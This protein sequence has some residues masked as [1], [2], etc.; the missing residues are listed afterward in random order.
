MLSIFFFFFFFKVGI[1]LGM[2]LSF[3]HCS[4]THVYIFFLYFWI[5]F[6]RFILHLPSLARRL[7][8][9]FLRYG[10]LRH[11]SRWC[12][13]RKSASIWVV[14]TWLAMMPPERSVHWKK[15]RVEK[16]R[17]RDSNRGPL[18]R[19]ADALTIRPRRPPCYQISLCNLHTMS[20]I[21]LWKIAYKKISL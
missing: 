6:L 16:R 15:D 21:I 14:A 20:K 1:P 4:T 19:R 2:H 13:P 12:L 7:L 8:F 10:S 18:G 5:R 3:I 9:R 17:R 11:D